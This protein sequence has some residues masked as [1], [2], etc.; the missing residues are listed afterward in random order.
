VEDSG[1]GSLRVEFLLEDRAEESGVQDVSFVEGDSF[2]VGSDVLAL[3]EVVLDRFED[4]VEV[5]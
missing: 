4:P 5:L 2:F 1:D 3:G